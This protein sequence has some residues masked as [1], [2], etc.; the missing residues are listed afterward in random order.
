[1]CVYTHTHVH[2][3]FYIYIILYHDPPHS[4]FYTPPT[5]ILPSF[6]WNGEGYAMDRSMGKSSST[7]GKS[8]Q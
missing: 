2:T 3:H 6:T 7:W 4:P 1:M 8:L 5:V